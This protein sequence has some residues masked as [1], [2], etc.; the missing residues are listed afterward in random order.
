VAGYTELIKSFEKIRDFTRDFFI[1]GFKARNDFDSL[2]PRSYDNERRRIESYLSGLVVKNRDKRGMTLSISSN[3]V[4]KTSNP[5][6]KLWQTKS[7]TK[8][9]C[10]LNFVL[11]D[12]LSVHESLSI[13]QIVEIIGSDYTTESMEDMIIDAM[14]VR[15]KLNEYTKL[16]ILKS[17][18][19]GKALNYSMAE[20]PL[21]LIDT[22]TKHSLNTALA[23]YKNILPGGF[24]GH[25]SSSE[26]EEPFIYRQIFFAQ[27]LDDELLLKLLQAANEKRF[28]TIIS[29]SK[30]YRETKN[31]LLPL[32]V[33]SNT[34]TGRRYI[35]VCSKP[36]MKYS[37]IRLDYIKEVILGEVCNEY[38]TIKEEHNKRLQ[39]SFSIIHQTHQNLHTLRMVLY[40]DEKSE[41]FVL[42][43]L[44]RE[45]KHGVVSKLEDN[46]FEYKIEVS[47]TLEMVPWLRTF[48]G[49]IIEI[50]G[51]EKKIIGQFKKDIE[52][53]ASMYNLGGGQQDG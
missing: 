7:F 5:L 26:D 30:N 24:I 11:L 41:K 42:E 22:D 37:T 49:R 3:T 8:R 25:S 44:I 47:D 21:K 23:Y 6:F 39:S 13:S 19:K 32:K 16:G 17:Q 4:A 36:K 27:I 34:K 2:S 10:Y 52:A 50:E 29:R 45:G 48:I 35:A 9:D 38:D 28:V 12:I 31:V 15:N 40:I 18:K 43:R 33:L 20:N 1:Y 51:S 46:T 14:T 53:L